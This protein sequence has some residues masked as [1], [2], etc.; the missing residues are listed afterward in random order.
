MRT[1]QIFEVQLDDVDNAIKRYRRVADVDAENQTAIRALDRL[2]VQ[3]ERWGDL[4]KILEREAEIAQNAEEIIE[5]RYRLGQVMQLRLNDLDGATLAYKDVLAA[6]PEHK[7]TLDALEALFASGVKQLEIAE[8]LEPLYRQAGEFEKLT[9]VYEAQ[10]GH[11][12]TPEDRQAAYYRI[13]E[14]SEDKLMD[15]V[16]TLATY[17]RVLK[18]FPLDEK[19]GEEVPRLAA[20]VDGG[21][22]TL[23][24]AYADVLGLHT[25]PQVQRV[26]G[27][28]LA[29]TFEDELGDITKAEETYKHVL[30]CRARSTSGPLEPRS[31][32]PLAT[33]VRGGSR[34]ASSRCASRPRAQEAAR[35]TDPGVDTLELVELYARL[36]EVAETQ[37][38]SQT[39]RG[40][41]HSYSPDLRRPREDPRG[42]PSP[43]SLAHLRASR[44]KWKDLRGRLRARAS[45]ERREQL[46]R[47]RH[48]RQAGAPRQADRLPASPQTAIR[49]VE[50][51]PR[52]ARRGSG[53]R[54]VPWRTST[55]SSRQWPR[56]RRCPRAPV[57][58]RGERR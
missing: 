35:Q 10:L 34:R 16:A 42:A 2:F 8:I 56:A 44:R 7:P 1:A 27:K 38:L 32:L 49:D 48:P 39:D 19:A 22:E 23:A 31:H 41:P 15:P 13:A 53:R 12:E 28:R 4:A 5:L 52:S 36:G 51:R 40:D 3:T 21:W 14:L 45:R 17:I 58:H 18:E 20:S 29:K 43:H 26:I 25:D 50:A 9:G 55:R 24:N 6:S 54:S 37:R 57:R 33:R 30:G 47:S 11:I 46:G